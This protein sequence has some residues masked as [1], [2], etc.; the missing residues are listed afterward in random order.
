VYFFRKE[1]DKIGPSAYDK[2]NGVKTP[3]KLGGI[4]EQD[5]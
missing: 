4:Q 3:N 2:K 1:K 5:F